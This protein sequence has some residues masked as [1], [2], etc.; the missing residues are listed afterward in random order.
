MLFGAVPVRSDSSSSSE[1][2]ETE[3][4]LSSKV[5]THITQ[6][7]WMVPRPVP[8]PCGWVCMLCGLAGRPAVLVRRAG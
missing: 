7:Q 2:S 5:Q 6:K 4:L 1:A 8:E 3:K